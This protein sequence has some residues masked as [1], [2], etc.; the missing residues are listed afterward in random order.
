MLDSLR[1]RLAI[2]NLLIT[3][4]GILVVV[5][6]FTNLVVQHGK[7]IKQQE[8]AEQSQAVAKQVERLYLQ[9]GS[10]QD[11]AQQIDFESQL[12]GERII[13]VNP[14]GAPVPVYNAQHTLV[15]LLDSAVSTPFYRGNRYRP[16]SQ[17]LKNGVSARAYLQSQNLFVFQSPI[18]GTHGHRDGGAILLVARATDVEPGVPA[19]IG[20]V[21]IAVGVALLVWLLIGL[22]FTY[23]I[24]RPLVRITAATEKMARGDYSARVPA[25]GYG[26]IAR[27]AASYNKMAHQV[28]Q[29]NQ[30]LRDFVANVSHD[31]RTPLTMIAG[32]SQALLDGTA[33]AKEVEMSAVVIHE[34]A[35]KMQRMVDDL[36]QL[37]RLESG[38][39]RLERH[40][41]EVRP[42]VQS[43][44]DRVC[45]ARNGQGGP[46]I[47]N[48]V[49]ADAPLIEVDPERLERVLRNLLEN[50]IHYTPP[51]G[52]I[53]IRAGVAVPGWVELSLA[54]TGSG[55][56]A[57]E[58]PRIFERFYR[59]DK[60]RER[61]H[62]HSG[63]GLA[64]VRE[65]VEAH[66]GQ[67]EVESTLG[68]GT[69][70]RF[71]VP[72]A[73]EAPVEAEASPSAAPA[74]RAITR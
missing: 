53:T 69:T 64:I 10:I 33:Q 61:L 7:D 27:L 15:R 38:L 48:L 14:Q 43:V 26:E 28:Q 46:S 52:T 37:T 56:P 70:F 1:S 72:Q 12:L 11:L 24:S 65:I 20:V 58:L 73:E 39:F 35:N 44:V 32:F 30:V 74:Q 13:V 25:G 47:Q 68:R 18:Q 2:S 49:P 9:G 62:G 41:T 66:G 71:T 22:Y 6:I 51:D 34:E 8:L 59:S 19:L 23:S 40:P 63:L 36:L 42:F 57:E 21:A 67:V 54:D 3:F 31:L 29:T 4:L 55:I 5:V 60:S 16:N 50:A 17:A 45:R